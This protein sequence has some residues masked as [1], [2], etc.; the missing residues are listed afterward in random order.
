MKYGFIIP[1]FLLLAACSDSTQIQREYD[2]VRDECRGAAEGNIGQY[3]PSDA[4]TDQRDFNAQLTALFSDCMFERG[5]TVATPP[6]EGEVAD[7]GWGTSPQHPEILTRASAAKKA[8]QQQ[9]IQQQ[10][11]DQQRMQQQQMQH[12]QYMQYQEQQEQEHKQAM[13]RQTLAAGAVA[14]AVVHHNNQAEQQNQAYYQN[15]P[16]QNHA[17]Q[18]E[19]PGG[20]SATNSDPLVDNSEVTARAPSSASYNVRSSSSGV[21]AASRNMNRQSLS[22]SSSM[23]GR[24]SSSSSSNYWRNSSRR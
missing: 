20:Y 24:S 18:N 10:Q 6:R 3:I 17:W 19:A 16:P 14:G 4:Q 8:Q 7:S 11:I 9:Q 15:Q 12:Q 22:R 1:A 21:S 5:W 2:D 23:Y 13:T